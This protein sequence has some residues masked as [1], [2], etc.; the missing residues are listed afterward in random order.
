MLNDKG[1]AK[2]TIGSS[3]QVALLLAQIK[4]IE[5]VL[6]AVIT[7]IKEYQM[8]VTYNK[9]KK[10]QKTVEEKHAYVKGVL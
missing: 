10:Q 6:Y 4:F 8:K 2:K 1:L 7:I 5:D 3:S 9:Y